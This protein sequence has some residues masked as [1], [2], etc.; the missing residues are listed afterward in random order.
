MDERCVAPDDERSN[1][2]LVRE[3]LLARLA[4]PP[5]AAHP[6]D[7][8]RSPAEAALHYDA[9]LLGVTLDLAV[10]GVG[11]DGHTASLFPHAPELAE[12]ERRAVAARPALE[13]FV[14]RVTLTIPM[15]G[16]A[17]TVLFFVTGGGKAEAAARAFAHPPSPTT[18]ASLV[19]SRGGR[20]VAVLDRAA[21]AHV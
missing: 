18:P 1:F 2:R 14:D 4:V 13:P 7:T 10:L 21:A 17:A 19:R 12:H 11:A 9:A 8:G 16:A 6:I 15:V 3:S 20:T 5:R